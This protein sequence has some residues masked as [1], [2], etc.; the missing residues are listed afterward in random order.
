MFLLDTVGCG[1]FGLGP[2]PRPLPFATSRVSPAA[3]TA[4]G[5]QPTGMRPTRR[6]RP[7]SRPEAA[8]PA[9]AAAGSQTAAALLSDS[10]AR[11]PRPPAA[12]APAPGVLPPR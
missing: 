3:S 2:A 8:T 10:A 11:P 6:S 1:P 4:V 7:R 9:V 12:R 5:Y